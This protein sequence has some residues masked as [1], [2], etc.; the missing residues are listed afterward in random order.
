MTKEQFDKGYMLSHYAND[1]FAGRQGEARRAIDRHYAGTYL[2]NPVP[3]VDGMSPDDVRDYLDSQYGTQWAF[4]ER[5]AI[6]MERIATAL[7]SKQLSDTSHT[8]LTSILPMLR[9]IA[10]KVGAELPPGHIQKPGTNSFKTVIEEAVLHPSMIDVHGPDYVKGW[11]TLR[12]ILLE[13]IE[14]NA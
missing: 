11:N 13:D 8:V 1:C 9:L 3:Q 14:K 12:G 6:A 2:D 4:T 7:E 10:R 5:N